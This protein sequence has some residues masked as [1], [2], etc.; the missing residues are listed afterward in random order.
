MAVGFAAMLKENDKKGLFQM[1]DGFTTYST[2][3]LP[4]DYANG[5]Y[6]TIKN[7]NTGETKQ[8]PVLGMIGGTITTIFG[9]TQGGKSALGAQLGYSIIRKYEDGFF[10][11]VDTEK[12][13][14]L[15][16]ILKISGAKIGDPRINLTKEHTSIEDVLEMIDKICNMKESLGNR[17]KYTIENYDTFGNPGKV[18]FPTVLMIDSLPKFNSRDFSEDNTT[19]GTN[20]DGMRS[21]KDLSKFMDRI[22][23]LLWR[24]NINLI[25]I[26]HL[27]PAQNVDRFKTQPREILMLNPNTEHLPRGY[28]SQYY[29]NLVIRVNSIKSNMTTYEQDGFTGYEA[30][31]QIAK[32]RSNFMGCSFKVAFD[33]NIGFDPIYTL[34]LFARD[35]GLIEGRNPHLYIKEHDDM[36]FSRKE[37]RNKF[38]EDLKFR[39]MVLSALNPYLEALMG[40]KESTVEERIE[41]GSIFDTV[42]E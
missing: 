29:A 33:K 30:E 7:I 16:R 28:V 27:R 15:D 19:L 4:L 8:I 9:A 41:F 12:G 6:R 40:V 20:M 5:F 36:K 11:Y 10:D 42:E 2:G 37:F 23:D 1:D 38:S 21:A 32:T 18:W 26:N 24:Y 34:L 31:F 14:L 35:N 17:M 22:L 3:I 25:C 13:A 39:E